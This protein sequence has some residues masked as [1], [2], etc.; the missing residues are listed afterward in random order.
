[1]WATSILHSRYPIVVDIWEVVIRGLCKFTELVVQIKY[2]SG[3]HAI[4]LRLIPEV[5]ESYLCRSLRNLA[6]SV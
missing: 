4:D 6:S 3:S 2:G 5:S 1:M